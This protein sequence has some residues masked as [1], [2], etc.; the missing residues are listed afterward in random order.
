M[1][2]SDVALVTFYSAYL[3]MIQQLRLLPFYNSTILESFT[4]NCT[5]K[6]DCGEYTPTLNYLRLEVAQHFGSHSHWP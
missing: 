4:S 3:Q 5:G 6:K 2:Q 1:S